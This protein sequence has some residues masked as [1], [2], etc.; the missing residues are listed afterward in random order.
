MPCLTPPLPADHDEL[1]L[2]LMGAGRLV[3]ASADEPEL[4]PDA[5]QELVTF[6]FDHLLPHLEWDERWLVK[7]RTCPEGGLLA[8]AM[9]TEARAMTG[10][11]FELV[12]ATGPCEAMAATRVLHSLLAAHAHHEKLLAAAG[13]HAVVPDPG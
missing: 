6:C 3:R 10:A 2:R 5:R 8:D 1:R 13:G 11:V 9:R 7:A 4:F 12:A